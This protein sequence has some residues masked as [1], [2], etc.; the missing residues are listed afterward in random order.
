MQE[1]FIP[2]ST[3][4][5]VHKQVVMAVSSNE[6]NAVLPSQELSPL[7]LILQTHKKPQIIPFHS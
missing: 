5:T 4:E 2:T 7:K 3:L 1:E 6:C